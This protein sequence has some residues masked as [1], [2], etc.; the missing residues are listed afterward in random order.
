[1]SENDSD[2]QMKIPILKIGLYSGSEAGSHKL[3]K[4]NKYH[5]IPEVSAS[6]VVSDE[7]Q[8]EIMFSYGCHQ[9]VLDCCPKLIKTYNFGQFADNKRYTINKNE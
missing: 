6:F 8:N 1:M 9:F 4:Y 2:I 3:D 7:N 5:V